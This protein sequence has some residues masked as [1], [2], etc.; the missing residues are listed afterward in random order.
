MICLTVAAVFQPSITA[1][2]INVT[3]TY[4]H[5]RPVLQAC[6][7]AQLLPG[8]LWCM[9][10]DATA[11]CGFIS[12]GLLTCLSCYGLTAF[13]AAGH[14]LKSLLMQVTNTQANLDPPPVT[15]LSS[16][17]LQA[18]FIGPGNP[19]GSSTSTAEAQDHIFGMVLMNDWSARDIQKWEAVP[20]GPFAGKN[21]VHS[22]AFT[23]CSCAFH[24]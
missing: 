1:P 19:L 24:H 9:S 22:S 14:L 12:S 2:F 8:A 20:L 5:A 10:A 6:L 21:W 7:P 23:F 17:N 4:V 15:D 13:A 16:Y 18:A 3:L 11:P